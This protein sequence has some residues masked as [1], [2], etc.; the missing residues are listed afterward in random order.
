[1]ATEHPKVTAYVPKKIL[2]AL[3]TWK[4]ENAVESRSAAIV[5]IL[6]DYLGVPYPAQQEGNALTVPTSALS[7]VLAELAKLSDRVVA[8]EQQMAVRAALQEV[9]D[10]ALI[11]ETSSTA[12]IEAPGIVPEEETRYVSNVPSPAPPE[13]ATTVSAVQGKALSNAPLEEATT[14]SNVQGEV[15]STVPTSAPLQP[16]APVTQMALAKRLGVSD[17]AVEKHRKQGSKEQ[18]AQWSRERD[19]DGIAWTWQGSGGRGQ[20]LRFVPLTNCTI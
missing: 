19:P 5:V 2:S 10:T 6:A 18:F 12:P 17:K 3:D 14:A 15:P 9:P 16:P 7:T 20:P 4:I 1:V 11:P 8:L 13:D